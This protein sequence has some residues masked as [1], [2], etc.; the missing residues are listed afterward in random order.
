MHATSV[1]IRN[2]RSA[3]I[4][5]GALYAI[6][7]LALVGTRLTGLGQSFWHDEIVAVGDIIRTGPREI[8]TGPYVGHKLFSLLGWVTRSVVGESELA[9]RLWSAIPFILGVAIGTAWLH[10]RMGSVS[11]VLF[12]FFATVSPLLLDITRQARGYGL[13]FLAMSVLVVAALEADRSGRA[14]TIVA[15]CAAGVVGTWTLPQFGIA[16]LA[17]GAVVLADRDLRR[18]AALGL[19]ASILAIGAWY[20]PHLGGV[21][22]AP[23]IEDGVQIGTLGLV[24]APIDQVLIP[25]LLW[26]DGTALVAG[27][28]WLPLILAAALIIGSSPFVRKRQTMLVLGSGVVATVVAL[29]LIQA[30]VIPRYLSYLLVPL[31]IL[32]ATG[33]ASI[34]ARIRTRP[35]ILRTLVSF[36]VIG[37]LAIRFAT[38]APE[39]VRLPREAHKD[40]ASIIESQ[41]PPAAPVL[42]HLHNPRDLAFYLGRP[43]RELTTSEVVSSVCGSRR[44][45]VFVMQP[46]AIQDVQVP[47]LDR[48]ATRHYRF[49]QY[50]R[51]DEMNVWFVPPSR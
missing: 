44:P 10:R 3:E 47:C 35:A 16:F 31:F 38:I 12:L 29:W 46:F 27:L 2:A 15:F 8:L 45:V 19:G 7:G 1:R 41:A 40:A 20:A 30:Y 28:V 49:R 34:F 24:T 6:L 43:I 39:V 18:P 48:P 26:I 50:A 4:V 5:A 25:A 33:M 14:R 22:D 42:A 36:V 21:R 51:G 11:G 17:T 13:A 37:L 32:L 9:F 23:A